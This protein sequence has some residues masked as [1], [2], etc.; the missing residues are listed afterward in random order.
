[1]KHLSKA[2]KL[3]QII[4]GCQHFAVGSGFTV[5]ARKVG[6]INSFVFASPQFKPFFCYNYIQEVIFTMAHCRDES[7][8]LSTCRSNND[9]PEPTS[10]SLVPET[11]SSANLAED[12]LPVE[13]AKLSIYTTCALFGVIGNLLVIIILTKLRGKKTRVTDFFLINLAIAD[14]GYLLLTFPMG[15]TRERAPSDWPFGKFV[16]LYLQPFAEIFHGASVWFIAI[17]AIERYRKIAARNPKIHGVKQ[18]ASLKR[19]GIIATCI[20]AASF[21][22]FSLPLYFVVDY[23]EFPGGGTV[24]APVWDKDSVLARVY[25]ACL[26]LLSYILPLAVISWTFRAV[27]LK[28]NECSKFIQTMKTGEKENE[29]ANLNDCSVFTSG[30]HA[31]RLA[32]NIRAKRIL[33]PVV[34]VFTFFMLPFVLLRLCVV[35]WPAIAQHKFYNNLFFA[36]VVCAIINSSANPVIYSMV[37]HDFRCQL[38]RITCRNTRRTSRRR[39]SSQAFVSRLT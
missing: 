30:K 37:R 21:L 12:S 7:K 19:A 17:I 11:P 31:I 9:S 32:Q 13:A 39:Y 25:I 10:T 27:S 29:T 35:F 38:A 28:L 36:V 2:L 15:A 22:V 3:I 26:T 20:W 8:N 23:H 33:I 18:R 16:C 5:F 14:L 24:C 1:M 4:N 34:L 6:F